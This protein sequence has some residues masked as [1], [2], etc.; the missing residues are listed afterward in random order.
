MARFHGIRG[1]LF[2]AANDTS[3]I[4]AD[5]K[6]FD[7]L[8]WELQIDLQADNDVTTINHNLDLV[9][10]EYVA[11]STG[12][13]GSFE[14]FIDSDPAR[15]LTVDLVNMATKKI[16]L[17]YQY[18]AAA[19]DNRFFEGLCFINQLSASNPRDGAVTYSGTFRGTGALTFPAAT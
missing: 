8:S 4:E 2:V 17:E 6:L 10:E 11:G 1:A 9:W 12:W 14:G 13:T 5:T 18:S 3:D 16:R 19:A 15:R 7:L